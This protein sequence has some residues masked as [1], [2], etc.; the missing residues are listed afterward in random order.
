MLMG[1]SRSERIGAR[2]AKKRG[3]LWSIVVIFSV[4]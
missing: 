1:S 4:H 3:K 2:I